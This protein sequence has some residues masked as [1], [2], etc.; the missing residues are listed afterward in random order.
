MRKLIIISFSLVVCLFMASMTTAQTYYPFPDTGQT[1][2]YDADH[3]EVSCDTI[4][5]GDPLYGQDAT[6]HPRLPRSYTKMGQGGGTILIDNAA[7]VDDGGPWIISR[8][9][10]TGLI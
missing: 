2:C 5:P 4:Q 3:Q 8:D 10:V 1:M 9:N 7:H 6:Y